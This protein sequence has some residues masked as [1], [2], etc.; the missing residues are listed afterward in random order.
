VL[1]SAAD[2]FR[3]VGHLDRTLELLERATSLDPGGSFAWAAKGDLHRMRGELDDAL[4][5]LDRAADLSPTYAFAIGTRAAVLAQLD[6]NR[7]LLGD[8]LAAELPA[9]STG[10]SSSIRST[11]S[12]FG[13]RPCCWRAK[14]GSSRRSRPFSA[15]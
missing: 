2:V 11:R 10:R 12:P 7:A 13:Q 6:R 15:R 8:R 14:G 9:R 5:A 3:Q 1:I 4:A